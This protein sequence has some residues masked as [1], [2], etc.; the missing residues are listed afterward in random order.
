[1]PKQGFHKRGS[2]NAMILVLVIVVSLVSAA[3]AHRL[4]PVPLGQKGT[5]TME[6]VRSYPY[7]SELV[8]SPSGSR[9]AWAFD[10]QG[11][12]NVWAA[13]GPEFKARR[14][15]DYRENDGQELTGLAFSPDGNYV[16]YV[17]GGD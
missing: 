10:E 3:G 7:P 8:S 5:F 15:T 13:E 4:R 17:R 11:V 6:Q 1:M 2:F 9:I 16:V 12:R 14:L